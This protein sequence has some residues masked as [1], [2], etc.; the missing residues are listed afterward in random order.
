MFRFHWFHVRIIRY[1]S[2]DLLIP[3]IHVYSY[4][5]RIYTGERPLR[6][7][8]CVREKLGLVFSRKIRTLA[9]KTVLTVGYHTQSH[10]LD[11][12]QYQVVSS[13][14]STVAPPFF[15]FCTHLLSSFWTSRGH[16]CRPVSPPGTCLQF[17]SR[18]LVGFSNPTTRRFFIE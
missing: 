10:T 5:P 1:S 13:L 7:K 3:R 8:Q 12:S 2:Y 4:V 14:C 15:F 18:I 11:I 16:R 17:L 9:E 6:V